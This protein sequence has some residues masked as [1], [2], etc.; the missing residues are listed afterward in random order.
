M[1]YP[2]Q[3]LRCCQHIKNVKKEA[4]VKCRRKRN[5]KSKRQNTTDFLNTVLLW[6]VFEA[7]MQK[8]SVVTAGDHTHMSL[9]SYE[10][11]KRQSSVVSSVSTL[12]AYRH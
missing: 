1:H 4:N 2:L 9:A 7:R 6:E 3:D 12:Q 5:T 8:E 10:G 11:L